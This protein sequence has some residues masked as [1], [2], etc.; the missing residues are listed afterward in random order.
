MQGLPFNLF[1][2]LLQSEGNE[3]LPL[4]LVGLCF[5]H[6]TLSLCQHCSQTHP[7]PFAPS[8]PCCDENFK[9]ILGEAHGD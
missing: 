1:L 5:Q 7:L 9:S 6:L 2:V 3:Q 8:S 4:Q